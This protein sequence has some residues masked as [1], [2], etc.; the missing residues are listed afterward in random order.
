VSISFKFESDS[1]GSIYT[2][3]MGRCFRSG[4]GPLESRLFSVCQH[5]TALTQEEMKFQR[6]RTSVWSGIYNFSSYV[7][8]A[9]SIALKVHLPIKKKKKRQGRGLA[10]FHT[11]I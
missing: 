11:V 2:M 4:L 10:M 5:I 1:G 7:I 3:E 8:K 6:E 9:V